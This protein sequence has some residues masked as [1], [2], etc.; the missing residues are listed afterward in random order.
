MSRQ[1]AWILYHVGVWLVFLP[2][3]FCFWFIPFRTIPV[4]QKTVVIFH[5]MMIIRRS[6]NTLLHSDY[7]CWDPILEL[8]LLL[9]LHI[10]CCFL[11]G[12]KIK[13]K[14]QTRSTFTIPPGSLTARPLKIYHPK[15]KGKRLPTIHFFRGRAVKLREGTQNRQFLVPSVSRGPLSQVDLP[16]SL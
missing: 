11:R 6:F 9:Q 12:W 5:Y 8:L 15:R 13:Q 3:W 16:I 4:P 14:K 7:F 10:S 2:Q 1:F